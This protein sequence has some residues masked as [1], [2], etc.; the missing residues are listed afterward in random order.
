[1]ILI[2]GHPEN[3]INIADRGLQ[4]GDGL[5]ETIAYRDGQLEFL[6]DHLSRLIEGCKRLNI[7][8]KNAQQQLL[9][10][11]IE[12]VAQSLKADGV[13]KVMLTR[14]QGGRGYRY[15]D[16]MQSTRIV[17]S[18]PLPN[19]PS[20]NQSGVSVRICQQCLAVNPSL[21]GIKHL[22]RLEQIL[23]RNEW[24]DD[25]IAE[26]LMFD[27]Q[28]RLIEGTMSN[29]FLVKNNQLFTPE[30]SNSGI[31][32]IMR[33]QI[34]KLTNTLDITLHITTLDLDALKSADEIFICNS[35]MG[36]WPVTRITDFKNNIK[37]GSITLTLQNAL[38]S[39]NRYQ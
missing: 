18:H 13:I 12:T 32:G 9:I 21:A 38:M 29:V 26:G 3:R 39:L 15:Q 14:G 7:S 1:M 28:E 35:L 2:N 23:A 27:Y 19:Y 20:E 11:E 5:F 16:D 34:I 10:V 8:F 17:S 36:I 31:A 6:S 24:Q 4:Y 25:T 30:I 37:R 22:N 33:K